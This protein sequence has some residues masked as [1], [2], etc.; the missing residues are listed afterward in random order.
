MEIKKK[1][2][3]EVKEELFLKSFFQFK[4]YQ[5]K[6]YFDFNFLKKWSKNGL[7]QF[8]CFISLFLFFS[9]ILFLSFS[10]TFFLFLT[11]FLSLFLYFFSFVSLR[12]NTN[13]KNVTQIKKNEK[14]FFLKVLIISYFATKKKNVLANCKF[15]K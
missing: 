4:Y 9:L 6:F 12:Q 13:K 15:N 5:K 7:F 14:K 8:F 2:K 11:L 3:G 10:F 1:K